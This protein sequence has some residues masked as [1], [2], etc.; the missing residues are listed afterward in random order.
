MGQIAEL[1]AAPD[2]IEA[3]LSYLAGTGDKLVTYVAKPGGKDER[4]GGDSETH[5]VTLNNGRPLVDRFVFEREG[6][7]FVDH[8]SRVRSF[9]DEDEIR[10]V[11]YPEC[12]ALIKQESGAKR[13]VV[14]D[15]TLRTG[16]GEQREAQKIRDV[17]SRV[18]NDYTE[19][20]GPQ[21]VRDIMGDEAEELLRGRFAII[22]VW[23]PINHPVESH[24]L[25]ICDAQTVS[26]GN[27]VINE[28]RY[29]GR[30]GQTYAITYDPQQRWYWFP[31]MRPDEA[32]VFKVYESLRDGRA[33]WTA[34]TAF[35][36]PTSPPHARARES[37][38]IRTLAFF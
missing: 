35:E 22:Q 32:L 17:V 16:S 37:I 25:A 1:D 19:W 30:V 23:R 36:D 3:D 28:R 6:F 13:V 24:P 21:R 38:E 2:T 31:Q 18:H 34:H 4:S 26:P 8:H 14:F 29:P 27:L 10:R 20:S 7:R 33:R 5:R 12:E 9:F 11:Y 15:H